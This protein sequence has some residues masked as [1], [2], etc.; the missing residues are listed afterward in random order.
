MKTD[1]GQALMNQLEY[2]KD[3][4]KSTTGNRQDKV[5]DVLDKL[6]GDFD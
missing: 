6:K 2:R 4:G 1:A 3:K 5:E